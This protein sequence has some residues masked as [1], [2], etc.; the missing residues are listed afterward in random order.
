M[1][2]TPLV[3]PRAPPPDRRRPW[4]SRSGRSVRRGARAWPRGAGA[5]CRRGPSNGGDVTFAGHSP[6]GG[7]SVSSRVLARLPESRSD[8]VCDLAVRVRVRWVHP[9]CAPRAPP[10]VDSDLV[11]R[12]GS[13]SVMTSVTNGVGVGLLSLA[14]QFDVSLVLRGEGLA[15]RTGCAVSARSVEGRGT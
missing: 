2:C 3:H 15:P 14:L 6:V 5:R 4:R 10:R 13:S 8:R 7:G 1:G 12:G 9:P 11:L